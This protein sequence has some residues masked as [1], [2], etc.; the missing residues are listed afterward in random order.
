[1][2]KPAACEGADLTAYEI[3]MGVS[4][5]DDAPAPFRLDTRSGQRVDSPDG[6]LDGE[7]LTLGTYLH[8]LFHN[9][10]LR[11]GVLAY[12]AGRKGA[13]LP[14]PAGDIDPDA[15]Y[16]KLAAHVREHLDMELVYRVMGLER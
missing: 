16:D 2:L 14:P 3:H 12:V 4:P 13:T 11:R 7:G 15:E 6:A 1:M 8:G 10:D 9:R 5:R